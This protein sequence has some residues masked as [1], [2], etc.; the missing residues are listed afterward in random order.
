MAVAA[1]I[2][3]LLK[4]SIAFIEIKQCTSNGSFAV[5][6]NGSNCSSNKYNSE[7]VIVVLVLAKNCVEI[8]SF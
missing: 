3:V 8:I 1:Y 7:G 2:T 6:N 4:N 5:S